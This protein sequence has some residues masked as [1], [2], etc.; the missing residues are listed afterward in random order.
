MAHAPLVYLDSSDFSVLSSETRSSDHEA[1]RRD[2]VAMEKTGEVRF[3]F[4][5]IHLME[6]A[7]VQTG[8]ATRAAAAR[9]DLL[10]ELCGRRALASF[11]RLWEM[12]LGSLGRPASRVEI[13]VV[14]EIGEWYPEWDDALIPPT[15]WSRLWQGISEETKAQGLNRAARRKMMPKLMRSG[16]PTRQGRQMLAE[17]ANALEYDHL[18]RLYPMREQDARTLA[19]YFIGQ[20]TARDAKDAFLE[21]L[22]DPRWM[23]RWFVAHADTLSAFTDWIRKPGRDMA[24]LVRQIAQSAADLRE[25]ASLTGTGSQPEIL[26]ARGW[27]AA[28]EDFLVN[29]AAK[30]R[31]AMCPELPQYRASATEI[32]LLCPGLAVTVRSAHSAMRSSTTAERPRSPK[33]SDFADAVHGLYAPYVDVFR[34]DGFMAEHIA[35][36]VPSRTRVVPKLSHLLPT[37]RRMLT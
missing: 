8:F 5:G 7:P 36:N 12:E 2:L 13:S 32:D 28:Q 14:N 17:H 24:K 26:T 21:S 34:T 11:D 15:P 9:A 18:V 6:L 23:I 31:V 20:A 35:A 4:S 16:R 33:D 10:V 27:K 37:L 30:A 3:V 1:L 19:K 29:I 25:F 22:R